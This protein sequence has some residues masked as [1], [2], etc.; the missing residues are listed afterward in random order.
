M[1]CKGVR[2]DAKYD[3]ISKSI[4]L[5]KGSHIS[6]GVVEKYKSKRDRQIKD[7]LENQDE[8]GAL[9]Y[10]VIFETVSGAAVFISGNDVNGWDAWKTNNEQTI[11]NVY[12]K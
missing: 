10:D 6:L 5:V 4:L 11:N 1:T 3:P 8:S 2:V 9:K 7:Y 12:R